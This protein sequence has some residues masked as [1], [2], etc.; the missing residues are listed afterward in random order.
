M[1]TE[2][3]SLCKFQSSGVWILELLLKFI[4]SLFIRSIMLNPAYIAE[5]LGKEQ[6]IKSNDAVDDETRHVPKHFGEEERINPKLK[7]W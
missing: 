2:L 6:N 1:L 7:Q 4:L 3:E 5:A